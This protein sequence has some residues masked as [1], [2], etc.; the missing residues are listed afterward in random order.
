MLSPTLEVKTGVDGKA[1][2]M[3][4]HAMSPGCSAE[5]AVGLGAGAITGTLFTVCL[6]GACCAV[7]IQ[8]HAAHTFE[9]PDELC[10]VG[11]HAFEI[12]N[13]SSSDSSSST[14]QNSS[15]AATDT[16][17]SL[18]ST[19]AARDER[20]EYEL[21][22]VR[23][24]S[25]NNDHTP[26][27]QDYTTVGSGMQTTY[28][29]TRNVDGGADFTRDVRILQDHV[30]VSDGTK[31]LLVPLDTSTGT[32]ATNATPFTSISSTSAH[33]AAHAVG[34]TTE[35][36]E[37]VCALATTEE[38]MYAWATCASVDLTTAAPGDQDP[39]VYDSAAAA[40]L[41][42]PPL[43]GQ[44][45]KQE[46]LMQR[47]RSHAKDELTKTEECMG[48]LK[49]KNDLRTSTHGQFLS[50]S[51]LFERV[52]W[53]EGGRRRVKNVDSC[54]ALRMFIFARLALTLI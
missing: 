2:P 49:A 24:L 34:T 23:P 15:A 31:E 48:A 54:V 38:G 43:P 52:G 35:T 18:A 21:V 51:I 40:S 19:S 26:R 37:G 4:V 17:V 27:V 1:W 16:D 30:I 53:A 8:R 33:S 42:T 25:V 44:D 29:G 45:L 50:F 3:W 6:F 12:N 10:R 13:P 7:R 28:T 20:D 5:L 14:A 47:Y 39:H 11:N 46:A 36:E 22:Q 9:N 32:I 41:L